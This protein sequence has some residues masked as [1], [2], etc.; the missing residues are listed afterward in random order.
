MRLRKIKRWPNRDDPRGIDLRVGHVVMTLDVVEVHGV[1]D[2][3]LLIQ[4]H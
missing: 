4:I 3:G 1:D 2:A